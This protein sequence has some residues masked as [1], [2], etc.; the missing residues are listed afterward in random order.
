MLRGLADDEAAAEIL[1]EPKGKTS[2]QEHT[3]HLPILYRSIQSVSRL[4]RTAKPDARALSTQTLTA[5][6]F[7]SL[8]VSPVFGFRLSAVRQTTIIASRVFGNLAVI[9]PR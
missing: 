1:A 7:P 9:N 5:P 4:K 3:L 6:P 8:R 2:T